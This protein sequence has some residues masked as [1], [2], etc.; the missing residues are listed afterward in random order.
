MLDEV[1]IG[2]LFTVLLPLLLVGEAI[3]GLLLWRFSGHPMPEPLRR[4]L[5]AGGARAGVEIRLVATWLAASAVT[6]WVGFLIAFVGIHVLL[7]TIGQ[8]AAL[9]GL[10]ASVVALAAVPIVWAVV[11]FRRSHG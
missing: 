6:M 10:L 7:F 8:T 5:A 9:I 3:V 4:P 11:L 1:S 2:T